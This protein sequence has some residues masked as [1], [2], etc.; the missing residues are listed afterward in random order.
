MDRLEAQASVLSVPPA[1]DADVAADI[2]RSSHAWLSEL[3]GDDSDPISAL[4]IA[5]LLVE[6]QG[7]MRI[8]DPLRAELAR[9][10]ATDHPAQYRESA[11]A[12]SRHARNGFHGRLAHLLGDRGAMVSAATLGLTAADK[13][14]EREQADWLLEVLTTEP[15]RTVDAAAAVRQL[16]R[17]PLRRPETDRLAALLHGLYEW[18]QGCQQ[19]ASEQFE[20]VLSQREGDRTEAIAEY[21]LGAYRAEQGDHSSGLLHLGAAIDLLRKLDDSPRL[22][23]ALLSYG[24]ALIAGGHAGAASID[25]V[26]VASEQLRMATA[27]LEEAVAIAI[28]V[29]DDLI[30]GLALLELSRVE[31][32]SERIDAAIKLAEDAARALADHDRELLGALTFMGFLY[33]EAGLRD[34]AR[35]ALTDAANLAARTEAP[36]LSLAR[37]LNFQASMDQRAGL[38][39]EA[40]DNARESV[41]IGRRSGDRQHTAIAL[42]TLAAILLDINSADATNEA[43]EYLQESQALLKDID[44]KNGIEMV[45]RTLER[46]RSSPSA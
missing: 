21:L 44:D 30:K 13:E 11:T 6:S 1:F 42:H 20:L 8:A 32:S 18:G 14:S 2:L 43:V 41:A 33:R 40:I 5:G 38:V 35:Q 34:E 16:E 29:G 31:Y 7:V 22:A 10:L 39:H 45:E 15:V 9:R 25:T 27:A 46:A 17:S 26:E 4:R 19:N 12:F 23:K 36:D 3:K 37:L 24:R 28:K